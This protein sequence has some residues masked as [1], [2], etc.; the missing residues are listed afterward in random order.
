MIYIELIELKFC[1]L[2]FHL[3]KNIEQRSMSETQ[4]DN[5]LSLNSELE[6]DDYKAMS[7]L[8]CIYYEMKDYKQAWHW[9]NE[10]A[11][12]GDSFAYFRLFFFYKYGCGDIEP[13]DE[14]AFKWLIKA[15]END[16]PPAQFLLGL[17]YEE[18]NDVTQDHEKAVYW[19]KKAA[20]KGL[21]EAKEK[22]KEMGE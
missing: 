14:E 8:A 7:N 18:G 17:S 20:D 9:M 1:K 21:K 16:M 15:A 2:D 5:I 10:A 11:N 13:N 19:I 3:R 22:L 6:Q 12:R 4:K